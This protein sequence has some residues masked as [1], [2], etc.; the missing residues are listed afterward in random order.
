MF[1]G[2][3]EYCV[4]L[5]G[6]MLGRSTRRRRRIQMVD[7]LLETKNYADLNKAAEDRSIWRTIKTDCRKPAQ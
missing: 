2:M 6:R 3:T 1:Y 4:T 7:D 5:V